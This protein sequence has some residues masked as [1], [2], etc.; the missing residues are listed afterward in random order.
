MNAL[1]THKLFHTLIVIGSGLTACGGSA[2]DSDATGG[3]GGGDPGSG[4]AGTSGTGGLAT[5]GTGTGGSVYP[6]PREVL[7]CT[8]EEWRCPNE[9]CNSYLPDPD[10]CTCDETA[11]RAPEDCA[12]TED[13]VCSEQTVDRAGAPLDTPVLSNCRCEPH[14][15]DC[16]LPDAEAKGCTDVPTTRSVIC[17]CAVIVL[18]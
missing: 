5:G 11:P 2:D 10:L 16:C 1:S 15:A 7:P 6:D 13:F 3:T 14:T 12:A 4:G 8:P 9:A 18:K 17:G